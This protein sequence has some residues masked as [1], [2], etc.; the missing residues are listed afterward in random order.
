MKTKIS[1]LAILLSAAFVQAQ[2]GFS[3][4]PK[5]GIATATLT[6]T[7]E[8]TNDTYGTWQA[9][10]QG[11]YRFNEKFSLSLEA[12]F[13]RVG[14]ENDDI[15]TYLYIDYINVPLLLRYFP[16]A[17]FNIHAGP[18]LGF[19]TSST[20]NEMNAETALKSTNFAAT[21]GLGYR[22]D[23]GLTMDVR[24]HAGLSDISEFTVGKTEMLSLGIGYLFK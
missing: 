19:L 9:G 1:L 2:T 23:F 15:Q 11:D 20:V 3:A 22:F 18:E 13:T 21:A 10:A 8:G 6:N 14:A 16:V 4:G 7:I 5:V 24:Y 17:G 12:Y